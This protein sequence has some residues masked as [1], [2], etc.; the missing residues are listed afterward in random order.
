MILSNLILK[1]YDHKIQIREKE[2]VPD[3]SF[4]KSSR[5]DLKTGAT[6]YVGSGNEKTENEKGQNQVSN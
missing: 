3:K 4:L 2:I 5:R 1:Q 6:M